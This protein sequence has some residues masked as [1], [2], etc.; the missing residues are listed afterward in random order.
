MGPG[1][2]TGLK[3]PTPLN[4]GGKEVPELE[5]ELGWITG[6]STPGPVLPA[7]QAFRESVLFRYRPQETRLSLLALP[8]EYS[9]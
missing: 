7:Q 6:L 3:P 8:P 2:W 1:P 4:K 9:E 5:A